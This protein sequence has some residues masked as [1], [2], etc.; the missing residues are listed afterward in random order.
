MGIYRQDSGAAR[1]R[2]F[3]YGVVLAIAGVFSL[4]YFSGVGDNSATVDFDK[5]TFEDFADSAAYGDLA[6][7]ATVVDPGENV[8]DA[9]IDDTPTD[10]GEQL[11]MPVVVAQIQVVTILDSD[12]DFRASVR[13]G[14][15]INVIITQTPYSGGASKDQKAIAKG[16]EL[17]LSL[18][19]LPA[20]SSAVIDTDAFTPVGMDNGVIAVAENGLAPWESIVTSVGGVPMGEATVEKLPEIVPNLR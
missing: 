2:Y 16:D 1:S 13:E 11:G 7:V 20:G 18:E 10:D 4:L 5:P 17:L 3:A 14:D 12:Q 8:V 15:M 6:I 9:G 19:Y